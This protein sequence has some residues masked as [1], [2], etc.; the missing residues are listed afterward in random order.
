MPDTL[1]SETIACVREVCWYLLG[2][3]SIGA[4]S[5]ALAYG[6]ALH[7][8]AAD[9]ADR[10]RDSAGGRALV[11]FAWY[12]PMVYATDRDLR[13][14]LNTL[15]SRE[16]PPQWGDAERVDRDCNH[17]VWRC[18][19]ANNEGNHRHRR[20]GAAADERLD[21][22]RCPRPCGPLITLSVR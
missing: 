18:P 13:H 12:F 6:I 15:I 11:H 4:L 20:V 3:N 5:F 2:P 16:K 8:L 1:G 21:A 10:A 9:A 17:F 7:C 14:W 19:K 22:T